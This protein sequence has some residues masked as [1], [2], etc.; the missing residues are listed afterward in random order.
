VNILEAADPRL[1]PTLRSNLSRHA[2]QLAQLLPQ[3]R[4]VL[5]RFED[6]EHL[7]DA[8]LVRLLEEAD[9]Q[10]RVLALAGASDALVQ[11]CLSLLSIDEASA[12]KLAWRQMGP[13]S[14]SDLETAQQALVEVAQQHETVAAE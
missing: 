11:R 2:P 12:L 5:N 7:D 10:T 14:L 6:L 9:P 3:H 13:T 4:S 8:A 1:Q